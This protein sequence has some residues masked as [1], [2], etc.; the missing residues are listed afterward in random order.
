[1]CCVCLC[2]HDHPIMYNTTAPYLLGSLSFPGFEPCWEAPGGK[3]PQMASQ[4]TESIVWPMASGKIKLSVLQFQGTAFCQPPAELQMRL[5]PQAMPWF[6]LVRPLCGGH[7]IQL[8]CAQTPTHRNHNPVCGSSA[9][10]VAATWNSDS[11]LTVLRR[12]TPLQLPFSFP[13]LN[14]SLWCVGLTA[15]CINA[16]TWG[17]H[18]MISL[19]T[20]ST[21][22][23]IFPKLGQRINSR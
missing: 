12:K 23:S 15:G 2:A 22:T 14:C 5:Q 8:N 18:D 9:E 21:L 19:W 20:S 6:S 4:G 13:A 1:M 11:W 7:V 3:E 17:L 10:F 16:W